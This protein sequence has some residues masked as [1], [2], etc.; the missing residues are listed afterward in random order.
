MVTVA[1]AR[2]LEF[3]GGEE[4]LTVCARI[5]EQKATLAQKTTHR[6]AEKNRFTSAT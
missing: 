6:S 4:M 3:P 2:K 1:G 5:V